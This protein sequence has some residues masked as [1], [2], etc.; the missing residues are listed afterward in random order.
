MG[1]AKPVTTNVTPKGYADPP[2]AMTVLPTTQNGEKSRHVD[3]LGRRRCVLAAYVM[4]LLLN[5][6]H[7][8]LE[9]HNRW[10]RRDYA[11]AASGGLLK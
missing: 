2:C 5:F 11:V 4:C 3:S 6:L 9:F 7:N 8:L 10:V 1:V